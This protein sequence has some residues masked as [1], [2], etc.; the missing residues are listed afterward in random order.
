MPCEGHIMPAISNTR[1][2]FSCQFVVNLRCWCPNYSFMPLPLV[3]RMSVDA[4]YCPWTPRGPAN[5]QESQTLWSVQKMEN[6]QQHS[7]LTQISVR[8]IMKAG[9]HLSPRTYIFQNYKI[10]HNFIWCTYWYFLRL[11]LPILEM[12][13]NI[14]VPKWIARVI[15]QNTQETWIWITMCANS[16]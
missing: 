11:G 7:A 4:D 1:N 5:C 16:Q 3:Y 15:I 2:Q 12:P 13:R 10:H 8:V 6:F 14:S 9:K